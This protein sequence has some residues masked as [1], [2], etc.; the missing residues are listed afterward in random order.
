[1]IQYRTDD[2][3]TLHT[4]LLFTSSSTR[5]LEFKRFTHIYNGLFISFFASVPEDRR[6]NSL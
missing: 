1:M 6:Q 5:K 4:V 2:H 3:L